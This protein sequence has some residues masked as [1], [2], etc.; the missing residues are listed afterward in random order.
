MKDLIKMIAEALV[1]KPEQVSVEEVG[2]SHTSVLELK[3]AKMDVG[4]IIGRHGRTASAMRTILGAASAR[5]KKRAM[6]EIVE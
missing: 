3:V 4:K 1:D 5:E 2:G 6:L